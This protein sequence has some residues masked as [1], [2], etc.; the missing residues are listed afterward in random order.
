MI[1]LEQVIS[2]ETPTHK[3]R[4]LLSK[5]KERNV[6]QK[7]MLMEEFIFA[8]VGRAI[9]PTLL[10]T[11][12]LRQNTMELN[13]EGQRSQKDQEEGGVGLGSIK[14]LSLSP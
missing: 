3:D 14:F 2:I 8:D 12:T 13:P 10:Y 7:M 9:F 11:L 4:R 1:L 6:D 5:E